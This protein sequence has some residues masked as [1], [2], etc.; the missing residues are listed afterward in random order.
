VTS[1]DSAAESGLL[2]N[3]HRALRRCWH[4]VARSAEVGD[5]P[6]RVLLLGRPLVLYRSGGEVVCFEDRC[7]HRHAP[8][9]LGRCDGGVLQCAYHGWRF[10]G[11]GRCVTI[12][13]LGAGARVPGQARLTGVAGVAERHG[14]VFVAPETP[15][16][17]LG[18]IA[19]AQ[20]DTFEAGELAPIRARASVGLLADNFLDMAH[21]PFVHTGTFGADEA[22][23]V[24][25]FDVVRDGWSFTARHRHQFANRE[26]PGVAAGIRPLIQSR[27][28]TYRL[29]A[30]FHLQLRID[31]E[32][33][34]GTNVI[35]F[36]LQPET[37]DSAR[38]YT[39]LW[40]NDLGGDR[41]AM[42]DAVAFEVRVLEEDLAVQQAYD[43][44]G[45]PLDP[46]AE[47]HT[48]AD[49]STLELRRLLGDLVAA[50]DP[51]ERA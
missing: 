41:A 22:A 36:F 25:R 19:E 18:T 39:T 16:A 50:A 13:A 51:P 21:F 9:S 5:Q 35:G 1:G 14:M 43:Q 46:T 44:P 47:L 11:D 4:P 15:L 38:I 2:H 7:P 6:T 40:R 34:G 24:P 26:D 49:R 37:D 45:L 23:E 10:G 17:P 29:D 3:T 33:S 48:R 20:D 28:L 27:R 31:F 12:P 30:P 32:D 42:A 8:L